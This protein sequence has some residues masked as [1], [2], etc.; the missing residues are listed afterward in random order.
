MG[1]PRISFD[2]PRLMQGKGGNDTLFGSG[3]NDKL[4]GLDGNDNLKGGVGDDILVGGSDLSPET[5]PVM[6]RVLADR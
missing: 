3:F 4:V 2:Q 1:W 5:H 6:G